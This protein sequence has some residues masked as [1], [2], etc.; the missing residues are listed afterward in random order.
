M[1]NGLTRIKENSVLLN[2][3]LSGLNLEEWIEMVF[4]NL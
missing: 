2:S 4:T 1:H 3:S